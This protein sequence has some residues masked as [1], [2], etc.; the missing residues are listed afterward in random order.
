MKILA[1]SGSLRR[2]SYNRA[3][4]KTL[5]Q[6]D[7]NVEIYEN[8]GDLP[9]FNPDLDIHTLEEDNS[10]KEVVNFRENV[11]QAD[12]F[13]ISTPEYAHQISGVLKNALDWLVSSDS[14]VAK[15]TVVISASTSDMG[16][17][18]A[19]AQLVT[20]LR[21]ISQN[22]LLDASLIVARVNKKIDEKGKVIDESLMNDLERLLMT[23][24]KN[25]KVKNETQL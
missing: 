11:R 4:L 7:N 19:H 24:R 2:N 18:K 23:V 14:I 5:H 17:D 15:P 20:L 6:L 12:V 13:V 21:V 8:L 9:L 22:V 16:G 1:L 10:P 25:V 3:I